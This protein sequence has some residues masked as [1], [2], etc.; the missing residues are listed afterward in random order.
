MKLAYK[1]AI[2]AVGKLDPS[3]MRRIADLETPG[4]RIIARNPK[5]LYKTTPSLIGFA[6]QLEGGW[7][8]DTNLSKQQAISR[9]M[10]ICR[11][12]GLDF[13]SDVE[14]TF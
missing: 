5:D 3:F 7:W 4:R 13:G 2:V 12:T 6:E 11:V 10:M 1:K 14:A 8:L 9:L